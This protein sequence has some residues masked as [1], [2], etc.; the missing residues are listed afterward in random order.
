M[1]QKKDLMLKEENMFVLPAGNSVDIAQAMGEE[2]EGLPMSFTRIK[3]PAGGGL[4]FEVPGD[5]PE[6]PEMAQ[7][8]VGVI[9]DHHPVNAYWKDKYSGGNT[10]PDCSSMDGKIGIGQPGGNCRTCPFNQFGSDGAG[11]ACKNMHRIYI[12]RSGEIF[13]MLL[14]LPPTS[15]KNFGDYVL[16][17]VIAKGYRTNEVITKITLTRAKNANGITYSQAQFTLV[18]P[19]SDEQ[20][21]FMRQFSESI[22][23]NTRQLAVESLEEEY[24]A[25]PAQSEE[26]PE[27]ED[28]PF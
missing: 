3:I 9:V 6:R 14:T 27:D 15:L 24:Y 11:K 13:P 20:R 4:S 18:E 21:A 2:M 26:V 5:D 1:S 7:E 16:K 23:A 28:L 12:L 25:P 22:K 10:P 17:R 8:L 19:L